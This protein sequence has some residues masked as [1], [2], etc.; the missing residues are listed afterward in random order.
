MDTRFECDLCTEEFPKEKGLK[1]HKSRAHS[2]KTANLKCYICQR[3]FI[4]E[5]SLK[6]H[7]AKIHI[8]TEKYQCDT[9]DKTYDTP[10]FL[11]YHIRTVHATTT[12]KRS[13]KCKFCEK[14]FSSRQQRNTHIDT[15]HT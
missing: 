14:Y 15:F 8:D 9:C 6:N 13:I 11:N 2:K 4:H 10:G 7:I 5:T 1:I 3:Y 12:R